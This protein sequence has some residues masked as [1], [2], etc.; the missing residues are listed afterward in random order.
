[1]NTTTD[2]LVNDVKKYKETLQS[3]RDEIQLRIHLGTMDV[4]TGVDPIFRTPNGA[5]MLSE[6]EPWENSEGSSQKSSRGMR[7]A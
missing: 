7:C 1:M 6:S 2:Q 5:S 3:L 4:K